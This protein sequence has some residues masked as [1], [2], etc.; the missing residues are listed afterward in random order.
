MI[1][2][3]DHW[4]GQYPSTYA[5]G[6]GLNRKMTLGN[7][8]LRFIYSLNSR[9]M[10]AI[11]KILYTEDEFHPTTSFREGKRCVNICAYCGSDNTINGGLQ[12]SE[13][14]KHYSNPIYLGNINGS[15]FVVF[16]QKVESMDIFMRRDDNN[17]PLVCMNCGKSYSSVL[18]LKTLDINTIL[19]Y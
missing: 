11:H 19:Y 2:T 17:M 6:A 8:I 16:P 10:I 4:L 14:K 15:T 3:L 7:R 13:S 12:M 1:G 9:L 5:P 18:I